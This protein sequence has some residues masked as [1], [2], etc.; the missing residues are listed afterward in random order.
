MIVPAGMTFYFQNNPYREGATVPKE[1]EDILAASLV[2]QS[3]QPV[4]TPKTRPAL[5]TSQ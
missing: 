4:A 2:A 5:D 1:A 3:P